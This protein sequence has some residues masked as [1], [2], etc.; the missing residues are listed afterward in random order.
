[1]SEFLLLFIRFDLDATNFLE[2]LRLAFYELKSVL[3]SRSV[4][5]VLRKKDESWGW[6]EGVNT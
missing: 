4:V 5:L 6:K 3:N 1:M 2:S